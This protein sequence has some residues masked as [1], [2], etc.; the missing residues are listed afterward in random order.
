MK[1]KLKKIL[2]ILSILFV[3]ILLFFLLKNSKA[4]IDRIKNIK[5]SYLFLLSLLTLAEFYL[6]GLM[7][8]VLLE[9]F[10][11]PTKIREWLG[12][13]I[14][15]TFGNYLTF[16]RG[17]TSAKAVYLKK[18]HNLS[19]PNFIASAGAGYVITI[20]VYGFLGM[21]FSII[22]LAYNQL[23]NLPLFM[24]FLAIFI[25]S[26]IMIIFSPS[27]PETNNFFLRQI[28]NILDGWHRLRRN[29][30][31]ILHFATLALLLYAVSIAKIFLLY[32][33]LSYNISV[34]SSSFIAIMS[35]LSVFISF[36]PAGLGI[37]EA[38]LAVTSNILDLGLKSGIYI[39]ALERAITIILIAILGPIF[40]YLLFNKKA[41][42]LS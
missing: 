22:M 34:I 17:G 39:S 6:N 5:P 35:G 41:R 7:L 24:L 3:L 8:K 36:T 31:F 33:S 32:K 23:F 14:I 30:H 20:F 26:L 19:Y 18:R 10:N 28:K 11:V 4:D 40:S 42:N 15:T 37:R 1:S 9:P 27:I 2:G 25:L 29:T 16:F 38:V 13:S 21:L 12:L